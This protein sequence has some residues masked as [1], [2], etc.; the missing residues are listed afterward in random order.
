Q[1][2]QR[3]WR[4]AFVRN[5]PKLAGRIAQ[6]ESISGSSAPHDVVLERPGPFQR[7]VFGVQADRY[8]KVRRSITVPCDTEPIAARLG[9][10]EQVDLRARGVAGRIDL[11]AVLVPFGIAGHSLV[12]QRYE[13]GVLTLTR[14]NLLVEARETQL[15][16]VKLAP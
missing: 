10:R 6:G 5:S 3:G 1:V 12:G 14:T 15:T 4:A 7:A 11:R 13:V 9:A 8:R 16:E 2:E